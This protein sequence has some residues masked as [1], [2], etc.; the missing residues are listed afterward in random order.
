MD[1]NRQCHRGN[2]SPNYS[3]SSPVE[4]KL[5]YKMFSMWDCL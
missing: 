3:G 4:S 5:F 1:Y 2:C